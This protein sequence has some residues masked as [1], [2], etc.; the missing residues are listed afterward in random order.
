MKIYFPASLHMELM[1]KNEETGMEGAVTIGLG[2]GT[3]A[4]EKTVQDRIDRFVKDEMNATAPGFRLATRDE[5]LSS[6]VR[7]RTGEE[8]V[9]VGPA[10]WDEINQD[11]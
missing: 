1:V 6:K 7:E 11:A 10:E 8:M 9:V 3:G 2:L 5:F 4:N